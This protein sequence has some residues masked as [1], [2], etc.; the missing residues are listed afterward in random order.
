MSEIPVLQMHA[1]F[2]LLYKAFFMT[3]DEWMNEHHKLFLEIIAHED[4]PDQNVRLHSVLIG[5][6]TE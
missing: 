5:F 2:D 4:A 1:S 6:S 3:N